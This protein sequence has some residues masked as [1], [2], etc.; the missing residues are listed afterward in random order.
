MRD[1]L[2]EAKETI[3]EWSVPIASTLLAINL[4]DLLSG[5]SIIV[6][7]LVLSLTLFIKIEELVE[8]RRVRSE[9]NN[10]ANKNE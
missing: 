8:K 3:S 1:T 7:F 6:S 10:K 4:F 9:R 5:A 2:L